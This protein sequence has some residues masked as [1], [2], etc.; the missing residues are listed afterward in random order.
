[1]E[2]RLK[3]LPGKQR[4]F[5]LQVAEKSGLPTDELARLAGV[6]PRSYRDWKREKLTMSCKGAE[7]FCER[8]NLVLPE[9]K[10]KMI[11]RWKEARRRA[12]QKGGHSRYKKYGDFGTLEGRRKGGRTALNILRKRGI[13]PWP[14]EF[15][16]PSDFS[17]QLAEFVGILLGDGGLTPGQVCIT[18]NSVADKDYV[19]FVIFLGKHLFGEE[20][21]VSKRSDSKALMIC[22][23]GVALVKYLIKIGLKTGNKVKQ[24]VDVPGW[25]KLSKEYRVACL[26]GLMD[27]D[28]GVFLHRYRVGGKLYTYKKICFSNRSIPLLYFAAKVMGELGLSPKVIDKVENKKVWLYNKDEVEQYLKLVGTHNPRLLKYQNN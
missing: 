17:D 26:R 28:G 9:G 15:K 13:I 25:I 2:I 4:D 7:I 16:F 5:L 27:T 6:V 19:P 14:K 8:F 10:G 1:M 20:P 11:T 22:Y 24:Q 12:S 23:S 18:L 3:F 21:R